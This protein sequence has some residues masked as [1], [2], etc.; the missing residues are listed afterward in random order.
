M[1]DVKFSRDETDRVV[2]KIKGYFEEELGQEIGSFE[3]EFLFDF[4]GK[5][6][7]PYFYNRGLTDAHTLFL[8]RAEE[9]GYQI[10]ELEKTV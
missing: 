5:E 9:V 2:A 1:N 3:A 8:E 10:Q 4:F 6:L 7:G